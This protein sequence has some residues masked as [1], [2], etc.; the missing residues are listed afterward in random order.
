MSIIANYAR[1]NESDLEKYC[2]DPEKLY[3]E[4]VETIDIDRSWDPMAWLVSECKRAEHAYNMLVM[5]S[6]MDERGEETN[7][8]PG[9]FSKFFKKNNEEENIDFLKNEQKKLKDISPEI[10]LIGIEGRG[11]TRVITFNP[12]NIVCL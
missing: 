12:R 4:E 2:S 1:I 3:S 7:K 11:N 9:F 5:R 8:K 6:M 10:I